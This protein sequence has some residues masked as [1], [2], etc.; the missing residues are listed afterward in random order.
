[1]LFAVGEVFTGVEISREKLPSRPKKHRDCV[2]SRFDAAAI[3][4]DAT[5]VIFFGGNVCEKC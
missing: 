2:S 1:M 4:A 3:C 5:A